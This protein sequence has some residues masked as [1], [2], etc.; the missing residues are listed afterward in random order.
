MHYIYHIH[1]ISL[2]LNGN[3]FQETKFEYTD[4]LEQMVSGEN[5]RTKCLNEN[6]STTQ[7]ELSDMDVS[8]CSYSENMSGDLEQ[9]NGDVH[10]FLNNEL[11]KDVPTGM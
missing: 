10:V 4:A 6:I 1:V 7:T 5:D 3:L 9:R 8:L 2:C 11:H